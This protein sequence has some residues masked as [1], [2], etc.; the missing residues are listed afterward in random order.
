MDRKPLNILHTSDIHIGSDTYPREAL[1]GL[2][3]VLTMADSLTVDAL[4][5]AGDLFDRAT[6]SKKSVQY[7]F[8][9]LSN[10]KCPVVILPGNHDTLLTSDSFE[11][12]PLQNSVHIIRDPA[13]EMLTFKEL[14]LSVWGCPVY[15]HIPS[16]HPIGQLPERPDNG[17]YVAIG[18]GIVLDSS[19]FEDR[20]SPIT[21]EELAKANCDYI[22]LGHTHVFR[23][24]TKGKAA[25]FYSG[26]PSGGQEKTVALVT[27]DP[28]QGVTTQRL[29][30]P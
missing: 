10:L 20:G 21:H 15:Q 22:A 28:A 16:F 29:L 1:E 3:K 12:P 14:T 18:H 8:S 23:D 13:G 26:A 17:W 11:Q 9:S 24:V 4:L 2:E 27:L 7:V 5:I 30:V 19:S 6:V 25:A